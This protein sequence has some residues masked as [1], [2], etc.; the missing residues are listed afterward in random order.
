MWE[1]PFLLGYDGGSD[2]TVSY[3]LS[4]KSQP[5]ICLVQN[6]IPMKALFLTPTLYFYC[7]HDCQTL[8][9]YSDLCLQLNE[10][11]E[12]RIKSKQSGSWKQIRDRTIDVSIANAASLLKSSALCFIQWELVWRPM[13]IGRCACGCHHLFMN[14]LVIS[15]QALSNYMMH[16]QTHGWENTFWGWIAVQNPSL[17]YT[18]WNLSAI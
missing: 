13:T 4:V 16:I 10:S 12:K 18:L 3:H 11:F 15:E 2:K 7:I 9:T 5:G 17:L 6:I 14:Q 1:S 8:W